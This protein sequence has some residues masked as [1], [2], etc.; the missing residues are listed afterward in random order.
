LPHHA[1]LLLKKLL[2]VELSHISWGDAA[3]GLE[4][5]CFYYNSLPTLSFSFLE[6]FSMQK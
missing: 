5:A 2:L 4:L 6:N 3:D 1:I